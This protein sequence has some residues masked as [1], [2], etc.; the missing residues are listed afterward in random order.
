MHEI[1]STIFQY[2]CYVGVGAR[3][4]QTCVFSHS[5]KYTFWEWIH[6]STNFIFGICYMELVMDSI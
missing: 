6:D 5:N 4:E 3:R 2:L 1:S